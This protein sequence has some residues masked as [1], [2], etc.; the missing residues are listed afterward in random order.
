MKL[1]LRLLVLPLL[2]LALCAQ[3]A[4]ATTYMM[5]SD[6]DLTDQAPA[7]VEARVMGV[8]FAPVVDGL[9]A[10]DYLVEVSRVLK[11]D[12]P[13]STVMVRVPGGIN[14][15]G[16]GRKIWGAPQFGEGEE[17]IL[18]LKPSKDGTYRIVHLMLGAFHKRTV[19]GRAVAVRDLDEA[20]AVGKAAGDAADAIRDFD[21][22]SDWVSNRGF[23]IE[24]EADYVVE[25]SAGLEK[26]LAAAT[27]KFTFL[28]PGSG[29]PIRWF[30]FDRG[31]RVDW[32]VH[33]SGQPGLSVA[34]TIAA[35]R[36]GLTAWTNDPNTNIAY[37]YAG[38]TTAGGGLARSDNVNAILFDDPFRDDPDEAVEGTFACGRGGV[39]AIGGPWFF[40]STQAY[41]GRQF[42]EAAEADIVTNDG[43]ECLFRNNPT[44]TREVFTH[45]LG[46]TLGL[47]H[48]PDIESVM[49]ASA[50]NDRRGARLNPDD[51]AGI[52][53]MY[54]ST[55]TNPPGGPSNLLAPA[56]LTG[57][58]TSSTAVTLTWR[59]KSK[60]EEG[61]SIEA[62][63]K[64]GKWLEVLTVPA[65]SKSAVVEDLIAGSTYA[66]RVRAVGGGSASPYSNAVN[67]VLPRRR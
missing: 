28:T 7:V 20:H 62:K 40:S 22:F 1:T 42:H 65:D 30:R 35:F 9:P 54:F 24:G 3:P 50:Q 52:R 49:F 12:L 48:S 25:R 33:S 39:I 4:A 44:V 19:D 53:D 66:F 55:S 10:T 43:T 64:G 34:D 8:E 6:Q 60:G 37:N 29:N 61:F 21:R 58:A 18:F 23:G 15:E 2:V 46:H 17:A 63:K 57:K 51:R 32:R 31:Q 14:P 59:D 67:L 16:V 56:R 38:T 41:N 13:G 5:M 45:E 36:D 11:G 26:S 47:G 27:E